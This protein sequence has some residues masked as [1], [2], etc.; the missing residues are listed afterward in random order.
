[1]PKW[2]SDGEKE[3]IHKLL[4]EQGEKQFS[5][6]GFKKTNVEEIA[7]AAG[8]SKGAF[9]HFFASKELL[10]MAVIEEV[11]IRSRR[12]LMKVIDEPGPTPRARLFAILKKAFDMF[13]ELPI[14]QVLTGSDFETL[15]RQVPADT[16]HAHVASDQAF[17]EELFSR[18]ENT[19]IPIRVGAEDIVELLYPLVVGFISGIGAKETTLSGNL[20]KHLEL[21]AAYCLGEITLELTQSPPRILNEEERKLE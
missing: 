17:F 5:R 9:Y 14:L 20:D 10:F 6:Y 19:G 11:E 15:T 3:N 21:I 7:L 2:F 8:I 16:F 12:E 1:M 13:G 4:L 18:C